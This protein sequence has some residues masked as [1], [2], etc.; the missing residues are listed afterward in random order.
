[1]TAVFTEQLTGTDAVERLGLESGV[2]TGRETE[3]DQN[4]ENQARDEQAGDDP[5]SGSGEP[6]RYR[7]Y[8]PQPT[9]F[10]DRGQPYQY[11]LGYFETDGLRVDTLSKRAYVSTE[12]AFAW[13]F[14][15]NDYLDYEIKL[16][17]DLNLESFGKSIGTLEK[18]FTGIL[19]G[20]GHVITGLRQPLFGVLGDGS[21]VYYLL[22][23]QA[24]IRGTVSRGGDEYGEAAEGC[25][26]LAAYTRNTV[27]DS[28]G[29]VGTIELLAGGSQ[30][31]IYVGGMIGE[32]GPGT[33]VYES[34]AFVNILEKMGDHAKVTA[35]GFAGMIAADSGADNC[36]ATGRIESGKTAGGFAGKNQG[37]IK[38]S[39][40]TNIIGKAA[41]TAG[42]FVGIM[43]ENQGGSAAEEAETEEAETEEPQGNRV[44]IVPL[45][46]IDQEETAGTEE[47]V[48]AN[49]TITGCAYDGQMSGF[50]DLYAQS[51]TTAE[52]TGAGAA[53][54]GGDWYMT[55]GAYPQLKCM[56]MHT[57]ETYLLRS[58]AS[59]IP[60]ILPVGIS[61]TDIPE[62]DG[63]EEIKISGA[64]E[65]GVPSQIDGD[66]IQWS[67]PDQVTLQGTGTAILEMN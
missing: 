22:L 32:A 23:D 52:M 28:C 24:E 45:Q 64:V 56:A 14:E 1:M 25:G 39:F 34:Y 59:A 67:D 50:S 61:L 55:D 3:E 44:E 66:E 33:S 53:L 62:G 46:M 26:V 5:A 65:L 58:K 36:Y 18:P 10:A 2:W 49:G 19:D 54:P 47:W 40:A 42:A 60:L 20:D 38:D 57:H 9:A 11:T 43:P 31:P 7:H 27:V 6:I 13:L 37:E 35:G 8:Y 29:A 48:K 51:M 41:N 17:E 63:E 16:E 4:G 21:A 15:G 12:E 30:R